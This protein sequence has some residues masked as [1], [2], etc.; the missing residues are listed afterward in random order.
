MAS[1]LKHR[2]EDY[3]QMQIAKKVFESKIIEEC[4]VKA[5][6]SIATDLTASFG[7]YCQPI[8]SESHEK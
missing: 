8:D 5:G 1:G 6:L 3:F 7:C 4:L 2:V